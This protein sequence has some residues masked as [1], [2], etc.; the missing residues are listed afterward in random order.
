VE[1]RF[2][3]N[4]KISCL[5]IREG[6]RAEARTV[7]AATSASD[8]ASGGVGRGNASATRDGVG[9]EGILCRHDE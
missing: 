3:A 1:R 6:E 9:E 8:N 2:Y 5:E 7:E 4:V